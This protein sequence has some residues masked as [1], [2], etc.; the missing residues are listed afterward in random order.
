VNKGGG[1][2]FLAGVGLVLCA[3]CGPPKADS[4]K[5]SKRVQLDKGIK[6]LEAGKAETALQWF[7]KAA[8]EL[9]HTAGKTETGRSIGVDYGIPYEFLKLANPGLDLERLRGGQG[10]TIPGHP[11][12]QFN[13]GALYEE[14]NGTKQN[15]DEAA[16]WYRKAAEAGFTQAEFMMGW[17]HREGIGVNKDPIQ[18]VDWYTRAAAKG[19]ESALYNL[20]TLHAEGDDKV[21]RDLVAA[22]KWFTLAKRRHAE[23][24]RTGMEQ[25]AN[26]EMRDGKQD[27]ETWKQ[28][29]RNVLQRANAGTN[30][31]ALALKTQLQKLPS[32]ENDARVE[33]IRIR[34]DTL[35]EKHFLEDDSYKNLPMLK[36]S[37]ENQTGTPNGGPSVIAEAE[38]QAALF[39]FK[40]DPWANR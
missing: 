15:M 38:R 11:A 40:K 34:S 13:L 36:A 25:Q 33:Y 8:L 3:A 6:A 22:W 27:M 2:L 9:K 28:A 20:G 7:K 29:A 12:A 39:E 23:T 14:G 31:D 19:L 4:P 35:L 24:A 10:V 5:V 37:L 26:R 32:G 18:A 16:K 1:F 30:G 21:E 17:M